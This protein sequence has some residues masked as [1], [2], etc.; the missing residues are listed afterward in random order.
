MQKFSTILTSIALLALVATIA[1]LAWPSTSAAQD[2][3]TDSRKR[4]TVEGVGE[5]EVTP[6][7]PA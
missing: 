4:I 7:L 3:T 5:V 6:I 2:P 1:L